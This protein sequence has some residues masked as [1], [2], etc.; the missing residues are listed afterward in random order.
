MKTAPV[1]KDTDAELSAFLRRHGKKKYLLRLS[2]KDASYFTWKTQDIPLPFGAVKAIA[3]A[4][5][6]WEMAKIRR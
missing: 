2:Y 3:A 4:K 5:A 1:W 6:Y